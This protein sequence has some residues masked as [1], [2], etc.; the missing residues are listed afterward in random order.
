MKE[1]S[2]M[3]PSAEDFLNSTAAARVN[4]Y[5]DGYGTVD[6]LMNE[7][8]GFGLSEKANQKLIDTVKSRKGKSAR[9]RLND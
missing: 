7:L 4:G 2:A 6:D 1:F 8:P 9:K 3:H 5:L